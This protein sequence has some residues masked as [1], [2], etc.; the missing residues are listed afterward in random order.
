M[1]K[2]MIAM[3]VASAAVAANAVTALW[4][5]GVCYYEGAGTELIS[6]T[7]KLGAESTGYLFV[8]GK[9]QDSLGTAYTDWASLNTAQA[10]KDAF[11]GTGGE[12]KLTVNGHEYAVTD[13]G[14][15]ND[16]TLSF[17]DPE[18]EYKRNDRIYA[19]VV[20]EHADDA[21]SANQAYAKSSNS[22]AGN[23]SAALLWTG[24][25][26][27]DKGELTFGDN[28]TW[29]AA[30]PE[31]TSGLLLLLGVAGLALKRKRA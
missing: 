1:K 16:G 12:A 27:D 13:Q 6:G 24:L 7:T 28:T 22:A 18:T 2:L 5:S 29:Y 11:S 17:N 30:V 26:L 9:D 25:D 31:P 8:L 15:F 20:V 14:K 4:G 21:W 10:I 3:M 23:D 19:I